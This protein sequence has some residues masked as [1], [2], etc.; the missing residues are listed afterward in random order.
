M[1]SH[2]LSEEEAKS[3]QKEIPGWSL[4]GKEIKKEWHFESFIEAFAFMTKVALISEAM[5]HHPNWSNA[6][7][8]VKINLSTHDL[9]GLSNKD[10]ELARAINKVDQKSSSV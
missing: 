8:S 6:Y 2:L 9:G 7:S 1:G 5:N 3:I 10:I 4:E